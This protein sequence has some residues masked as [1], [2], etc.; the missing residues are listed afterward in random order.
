MNTFSIQLV[1]CEFFAYHGIFEQER[2]NGNTFW[3]DITVEIDAS[4]FEENALLQN[5]IDYQDLY[6]IVADRMNVPTPLLET[7]SLNIANDISL[8]LTQCKTIEVSIIK[9]NPPI[10]GKCKHSK[11]TY[12]KICS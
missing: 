1:S 3:V 9:N 2:I 7:I 6:T 12:T 8:K 5:T 11:V 10:Q 4:L